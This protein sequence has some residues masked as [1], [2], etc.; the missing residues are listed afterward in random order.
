ML[1]YGMCACQVPP[2][3][4]ES[5]F[6]KGMKDIKIAAL[7]G[8]IGIVEEAG[9]LGLTFEQCLQHLRNFRDC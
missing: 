3:G 8:A 5:T 2:P 9:R 7:D 6:K 1:H 4:L